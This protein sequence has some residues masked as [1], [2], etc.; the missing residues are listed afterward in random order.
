MF[1]TA[2]PV[3]PRLLRN[4]ER[5]RDSRDNLTSKTDLVPFALFLR[6]LQALLPLKAA[7]A[8]DDVLT[9]DFSSL[10]CIVRLWYFDISSSN[11]FGHLIAYAVIYA[12]V[13]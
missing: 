9:P 8:S 3:P 6:N 1:A 11:A 5:E 12:K 2:R 13:T 4:Y 7:S 10:D